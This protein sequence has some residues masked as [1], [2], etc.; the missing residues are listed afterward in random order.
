MKPFYSTVVCLRLLFAAL[1]FS[2]APLDTSAQQQGARAS[3]K[4]DESAARGN[5]A[6]PLIKRTTT[7]REVRTFGYGGTLTVYG[8]PA[9]SVTIEAWPRSQVEIVAEIELQ[10]ES[11]KD[12]AVLA[13]VNGF[14]L[15][16]DLNHLRVLTL[17]THDRKYL[18]RVAPKL[19]KHLVGLP[20][21]VDY[22]VRVPVATDLE[23]YAG[24]GEVTINGTDGAVRLNAGDGGGSFQVAGGDFEATL[25]GGPVNVRVPARS[26]RGR[27]LTVRLATGEITV[28]LPSGF[29]GD[30]NAEV[31]RAGRIENHHPTLVVREGE[32]STERILRARGGAGGATLSFTVG[33]GV[34]RIVTENKPRRT[35]D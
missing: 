1:V 9:G 21:K 24:S 6:K 7:R 34:V 31:L 20:W 2:F 32:Q 18:K 5:E 29:S 27:G 25:G 11:E 23:I 17:G 30:L 3:A 4:R 8:A 33:D 35:P 28:E 13:E 16:A 22:R 10:A 26:W 19:P 15:D 12:L 14:Q